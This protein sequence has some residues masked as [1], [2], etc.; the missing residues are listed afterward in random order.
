MKKELRRRR[1]YKV[2]LLIVTAACLF[3]SSNLQ[4]TINKMRGDLG[5]TVTEPLK[6]APP[7]LVFTTV[8]L[9]GFRGLIAN[10]LWVRLMDLQDQGKYFEM[11]QLSD[12]ITKLEPRIPVVWTVAAWN[13]SYN[14]S[15]KFTEP[16]DRWRWVQKGI[17]LLRDE[18]LKYNPHSSEIYRELA[19]HFLHKLGQ[20]LD[21]AHL[22]YKAQW[23]KLMKQDLAEDGH[24]D[25]DAL[26]D[27]KTPE[28]K[29]K[30]QKL[31]EVYKLD[32]KIMKEV[33]EKYGPLDWRM[34]E[35]HA[36]YWAYLGLKEA[37]TKKQLTN[38]RR[39]IF[40]SMQ[41]AFRRGRLIEVPGTRIVEFAPNL[42]L[43]PNAHR[44]YLEMMEQETKFKESIKN[45]HKN[46]LKDAIYFLYVHNRLREARHWFEELKKRYPQDKATKMTLDE[47]ALSRIG[48][49]IRETDMDRTISNIRAA[50]TRS[51]VALAMGEYDSAQ[52]HMLLARKIW[53]M[54]M[55]RIPEVS[56]KRIGLPPFERM[57]QEVLKDLLDPQHGL[58]PPLAARLRTELGLPAKGLPTP[59]PTEPRTNAPPAK[60]STNPPPAS[61]SSSK[62]S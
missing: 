19:W 59:S 46:F 57:R 29:A 4:W 26:L 45:A 10:A 48:E 20:N 55:Q 49:D 36:I 14:I 23:A 1:L 5:L 38:L 42:D 7:V 31:Q 51:F 27:P 32:P 40:Q 50:L 21:D 8:V 43:I 56:K 25:W 17:E 61:A 47:Y 24:P 53:T 28:Q 54:Y 18:A 30:V 16:E 11:V 58:I 41:L 33:D 6:D 62:T 35:T 37:K 39:I 12:W 13:M 2:V 3:A 9:G 44:T 15:V 52:G 22:Y 60:P 34:P